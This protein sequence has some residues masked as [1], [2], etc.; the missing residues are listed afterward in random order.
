M[1]DNDSVCLITKKAKKMSAEEFAEWVW[2]NR[3]TLE[4]KI[5]YI[6]LTDES[7][8]ETYEYSDW[9]YVT[10][11]IVEGL[12]DFIIIDWC[13]GGEPIAFPVDDCNYLQASIRQYF[14]NLPDYN[15]NDKINLELKMEDKKNVG[16][17]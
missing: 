8:G 7:E 5:A 10:R 6:A 3:K 17:Y 16:I 2:E 12:S 9:F 14:K 1:F 4:N 15:D 11:I 13:G